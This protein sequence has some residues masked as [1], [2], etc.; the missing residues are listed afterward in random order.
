M[1]YIYRFSVPI[2]NYFYTE[3]QK[4]IKDPKVDFTSSLY[5]GDTVTP[6]GGDWLCELLIIH[7]ICSKTLIKESYSISTSCLLNCWWDIW[8]YIE[9]VISIKQ[10][11]QMSS[12]PA[13]PEN[14][15]LDCI[16]LCAAC[17]V[18]LKCVPDHITFGLLRPVFAHFYA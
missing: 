1:H 13:C 6:V 7:P 15:S 17:L 10:P 3:R 4:R 14:N 9:I 5:S 12:G 16:L 8:K 2:T 18:F 11:V